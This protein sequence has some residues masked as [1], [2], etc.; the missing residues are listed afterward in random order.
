MN[1]NIWQ[2]I[3]KNA[4]DKEK[5]RFSVVANQRSVTLPSSDYK[6]NHYDKS[7]TLGILISALLLSQSIFHVPSHGHC[8]LTFGSLRNARLA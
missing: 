8:C 5:K 2:S 3:T 1:Y 6:S 4:P 7:V